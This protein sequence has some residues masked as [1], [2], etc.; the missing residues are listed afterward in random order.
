MNV[1][2]WCFFE[3]FGFRTAAD[4]TVSPKA[5]HKAAKSAAKSGKFVPKEHRGQPPGDEEAGGHS[6]KDICNFL[7]QLKNSNDPNKQ[8]VLSLYKGANKFSPEKA[9]TLRKWKLD[10]SCKWVTTYQQEV[11]S[12]TTAKD[13]GLEGFGTRSHAC[14]TTC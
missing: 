14:Y 9:A 6:C 1:H 10:K 8:H 3:P 2:V 7:T 4:D 13:T 5:V 12:E 11:S